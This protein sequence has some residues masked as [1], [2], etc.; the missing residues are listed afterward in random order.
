MGDV[1]TY[2][3]DPART[4]HKPNFIFSPIGG[5]WRK[6]AEIQVGAPVRAAPLF[7]SQYTFSAGPHAGETHDVVIITA[8]DN[9]VFAYSENSLLSGAGN[10]QLWMQQGLGPA[11][12]R[13]GSNPASA[14]ASLGY[15]NIP[16]PIGI[17]GTPVIDRANDLIYV[18]VCNGP[19]WSETYKI[20]ALDLN[21][22]SLVDQAQLS[23]AGAA[24]RPTFSAPAQ[25]QRGGLNLVN[26]WIFAVFADFQ[27]GDRGTYYGWI[28]ACSQADL[29][30][31]L[32]LPT[33]LTNTQG[34]GAWG[35]GGAAAAPDNSVYVSTGN[36]KHPTYG[37]GKKPQPGDY[38]EGVVH[39][40]I[41]AG[42]ALKVVDYYQP[43]WAKDLNDSDQDFGGSSPI[44]LPPIGGKTFV[45]T[46]AKDGNVYLLDKTLPGFGNELWTSRNHGGLFQAESKTAPAYFHDP[47][48]GGDYV[49][50]VGSNSPGL[51]AFKVDAANN[52]LVKVWDAGMSFSDGPGS[53]FIISEPTTNRALVWS[54][55]GQTQNDDKINRKAVLRAWDAITG[56]LAFH[57]DAVQGNGIDVDSP[58]FAPVTAGGESIFVGTLS[59]VFCYANVPPTISLIIIQSTFGQNEVELGLPGTSSFT[60]AGYVQ[61]DGFKPS[62]IGNLA[63][64][65]AQPT[66]GFT[67]PLGLPAPVVAGINS[68]NMTAVFTGPVLPLD[69]S[70]PDAPQGFLFPFKVTFNSDAGFVAMRAAGLDHTF[71]TLTAN[72]PI[73]GLGL[74]ASGQVELTT[75]EDP[76]FVNV[77]PQNPTQFPTWLSFDLRFFKVLVPPGK[78]VT[79]YG[80]TIATADDAP[81]FIT[82]ALGNF[83]NGDFN[84]L[85]QDERSTKIEYLQHDNAGNAAFNFAVARVRLAGKNAGTAKQ[86][87]VFFRLFNA[88]T[89]ASAFNATTYN[90]YSDGV[91]YGHKIPLLGI[92]SGEYVTIPCFASQR[93][94]LKDPTKSMTDQYDPINV[95]D[96]ATNPGVEIDYFFGCWL[97]VN[98]P[99]QKVLPTS[100]QAMNPDRGPWT[101]V[102]LHSLQDAFL[103]APHQCL[104]AEISFDETPVPPGANTGN[105]DKLAQRNIAWIDGP[106]PG[107]AASRLMPHPIQIRPTDK[108]AKNPDELMILWGKTPK[109]SEAQL[110]LPSLSAAEVV[111]LA[112]LRYCDHDL[113]MIDDHT[114]ACATGAATL[115][116]LPEDN[117]LAAGLLT[118]GLPSTVT[119]GDAYTVMVRQLTDARGAAPPPPP[120]PRIQSPAS[121]KIGPKPKTAAHPAPAVAGGALIEWRRARGAFQ[122]NMTISTK[123]QLLLSEERLLAWLRWMELK[124]PKT[125]SWYPVLRR[126]IDQIAGRVQGFGGDPG[127]I[128]P[129]PTGNVG[130]K[131]GPHP[132]GPGGGGHEARRHFTGKVAMLIFDRFGD[133]EGFALDTEDGE[134]KFFNR[135]RDFK[136]LVERGWSER[137]RI[138]VVTERDR[139]HEAISIWVHQPPASI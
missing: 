137:L 15:S 129:S 90:T 136:R 103:S 73:K 14:P 58:N 45:I 36:G 106:N 81:S 27:W 79:Q 63:A 51:V 82:K 11:T 105:S 75:G 16:A 132:G 89:T 32:F 44:V 34:G 109:G 97:D 5:T 13:G 121:H 3:V 124:M 128:G 20:C 47:V 60:A 41:V 22:G 31:Q 69:A 18:M 99:L 84:A 71:I 66:F 91:S 56:A 102:P 29:T 42:P 6:Y 25:D 62:D 83:T 95:R 49:Y 65:D 76:R 113:R 57:S 39:A 112:N 38:F 19:A 48:G 54:V 110:Y 117:A 23:D 35:P 87:R 28:V 67:L 119:K 123:E 46:T 10:S 59:S 111:R 7:L 1:L 130:P 94:I 78:S 126:Y 55:D 74:S 8:A 21:T 40:Q 92:E 107:I 52:A 64:P 12:P 88:Q 139:P 2:H 80:A 120:P 101:G 24:D 50:V 134:R 30:Q 116:P 96:L 33:T 114:I 133:F 122:F 70:L 108:G 26:G 115:I 17:C 135:E 98:Q 43:T 86:V 61:L 4:G 9:R 100:V 138:T 127:K 125:R 93:E 118:I 53:P 72:L 68:M 37:A 85:H 131:G 104:I 77:N